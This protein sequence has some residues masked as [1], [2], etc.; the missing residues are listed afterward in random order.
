VPEGFAQGN[1]QSTAKVGFSGQKLVTDRGAV[2]QECTAFVIGCIGKP[3]KALSTFAQ[4]TLPLGA[5]LTE[6]PA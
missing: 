3:Q 4:E 2:L 6:K 1:G 5:E